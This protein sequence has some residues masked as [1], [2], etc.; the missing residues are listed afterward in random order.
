MVLIKFQHFFKQLKSPEAI[1]LLFLF[2]LFSMTAPYTVQSGDTGELVTNSYYLRVSHPPGYPL[3]T[4]LYH[5]PVRYLSFLTPFHAAALFTSLIS[6][7]WLGVL[8]FRF[9]NKESL[10][11]ILVLATSM[12]FWRYSVLPDV[13][14]LH[15]FF[16]VLVF[17]AFLDPGLLN[18][19]WIVFLISLSVV[20]HHTIVF[21][22]PLYVYTLTKGDTKKKCLYSLFF[23]FLAGSMYFLLLTFHTEDY[24]SWGNLKSVSDVWNHFLRSEYGTFNLQSNTTKGESPWFSFFVKNFV[25]NSWSLVVAFFYLCIRHLALIKRYWS[26]ICILIFCIVIYFLMFVFGNVMSL[27]GFGETIFERFLMQPS[28]FIFF[29]VLLLVN[30]PG[31]KLPQWLVLLFLVNAG[32]NISQNFQANNYSKNTVIEDL[33]INNFSILPQ[34]SVLLTQ[35]DSLGSSAYYTHQVLKVRPDVVH[36]HP[37]HAFIWSVEKIYKKYPNAFANKA[38]NILESINYDKYSYFT[39][40][41]PQTLPQNFGVKYYG[42]LFNIYPSSEPHP[43]IIYS[44]EV[45][46]KFTWRTRSELEDLQTFEVSRIYDLEYG[47]CNYAKGWDEIQTGNKD[48]GLK[49]LEQAIALSPLSVKFEERLCYIYK[50]L[51]HPHWQKCEERLA[52]LISSSHQQY[53]F[54]TYEK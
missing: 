9:R 23:G 3:W 1:I 53:Y 12:V 21:A 41:P 22:F 4:L 38:Y 36:I 50:D 14:S 29:I 28:L 11:I 49:S 6:C 43:K 46:E 13:F 17:L 31:T 39:N 10:S 45:S 26:Q 51:Q 20:N 54:Y 18:R 16:L 40:V 44:C 2:I 33:A 37:T 34:N 7:L 30:T 19:K 35:G 32:L 15:M 52:E 24:G 47:R 5:A 42:T 25:T 8:L 48:E 27:D